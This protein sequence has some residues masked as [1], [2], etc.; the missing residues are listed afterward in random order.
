[1]KTS[2]LKNWLCQNFLLLTKASEL[3]KIWGGGGCIPPRSRPLRLCAP[4]ITKELIA[5]CKKER[6]LYKPRRSNKTT[7]WEKHQRVNNSVKK[8][9]RRNSSMGIH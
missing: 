3:P 4:W 5:L 1:M 8:H 7:I 2:L 9:C 6:S